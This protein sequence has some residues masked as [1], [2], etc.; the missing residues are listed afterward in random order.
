MDK[1]SFTVDTTVSSHVLK[2]FLVKGFAIAFLG[3]LGLLYSGIFLSLSELQRWGFLIFLLSI[4]LV[5]YGLLPYRSLCRLQINPAQ[6][7]INAESLA[8]YSKRKKLL[9]L[10]LRSVAEIRYISDSMNYGIAVYFKPRSS[11]IVIHENLKEV[12][13]LRQKGVKVG[14]SL[15]F[16]YFNRHAYNELNS[17]LD[18]IVQ[19]EQA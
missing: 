5:T 14:A 19:M 4:G 17:T 8:F 9:T 10:P 6:F 11:P 2:H 15:F 3:A 12:Q 16:P 7:V 13:K 1:T 18:D